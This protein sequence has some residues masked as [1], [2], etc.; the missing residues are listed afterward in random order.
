MLTKVCVVFLCPVSLSLRIRGRLFWIT[1]LIIDL[2]RSC[3][4]C[5]RSSHVMIEKGESVTEACKPPPPSLCHVILWHPAV[6]F[7][8]RSFQSSKCRN[9]RLSK[10]ST[11]CSM[12]LHYD[13]LRVP[14]R[15]RRT[16]AHFT[17]TTRSCKVAASSWGSRAWRATYELSY[18]HSKPALAPEHPGT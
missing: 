5:P 12:S 2:I 13:G 16:K 17:S 10:K 14:T 15:G 9:C 3:H 7:V 4:S 8:T 6:N 1:F 18:L 11:L